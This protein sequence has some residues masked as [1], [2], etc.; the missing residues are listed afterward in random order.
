[1]TSDLENRKG[2]NVQNI[3]GFNYNTLEY[4]CGYCHKPTSGFIVARHAQLDVQW[5]ICLN[6]LHGSVRDE[7]GIYPQPLLGDDVIGL[8][9]L[10]S[11]AYDEARKSL[12]S[13]SYT[14]CELMCRKILMNVSVDK[15]ANA[16][17]SFTSYID[18][19]QQ[20]GYITPPMSGWVDIIRKNG[21]ESN[22]E[23]KS[24]DKKRAESTL[25]FITQLLKLVYE[26][27]H[28]ASKFTSA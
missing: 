22:H 16:G 23:I 27:D 13:Q 18:Y 19:I 3:S 21:N 15:G 14:A 25:S 11:S 20:Q 10:I 9:E 4:T 28:H 17:Q 8:P 1:M 12:S 7:W 2:N 24:P 5:L 26:M 6:C